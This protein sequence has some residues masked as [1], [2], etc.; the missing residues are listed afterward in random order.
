[1]GID[2][3]EIRRR[4][5]IQPDAFPYK[6]PAGTTYDSGDFPTILDKALAAADWDGFRRSQEGKC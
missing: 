6:T 2:P 3:A 4:N 1:M 5:H